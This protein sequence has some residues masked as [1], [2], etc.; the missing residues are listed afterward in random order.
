MNMIAFWDIALFGLVEVY[1]HFRG[2]YCLHHEALILETARR[3][4]P[5]C[6]YLQFMGSSTSLTLKLNATFDILLEGHVC[7]RISGT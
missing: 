4:A 7:A 6:F 2:V 5:E 3:Y 1:R